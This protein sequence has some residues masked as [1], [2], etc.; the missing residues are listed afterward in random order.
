MLILIKV[1]IT[2]DLLLEMGNFENWKT[3]KQNLKGIGRKKLMGLIF[4]QI[5][6]HSWCKVKSTTET[7]SEQENQIAQYQSKLLDRLKRMLQEKGECQSLEDHPTLERRASERVTTGESKSLSV[8][9]C[10]QVIT[11]GEGKDNNNKL[12]ALEHSFIRKVYE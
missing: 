9:K 12:W 2:I 8:I 3:V 10:T 4:C 5:Q 1:L 11:A 6:P 7:F